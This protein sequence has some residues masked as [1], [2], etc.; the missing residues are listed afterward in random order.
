MELLNHQSDKTK[1]NIKVAFIGIIIATFFWF[2]LFS[3]L[4]APKVINMALIENENQNYIMIN[5]IIKNKVK[6]INTQDF[7]IFTKNSDE[8]I[9]LT[10]YDLKKVY[11]FLDDISKQLILNGNYVFFLPSGMFSGHFLLNYIG[12]KIPIRAF[13]ANSVFANIKTKVTN[14][15][16][17]NALVEMYIVV[18]VNQGVISPFNKHSKK[19]KY[20]ILISTYFIN[21]KVPSF[22]GKNYELSS[23]IFDITKKI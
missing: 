17:N 7:L 14:Y 8:E 4:I 21:G 11:N 15:G 5:G 9:I 3:K 18:E 1:K 23:N 12:T 20:E 16:I 19:G 10:E 13:I 22:Y 6:N 2:T